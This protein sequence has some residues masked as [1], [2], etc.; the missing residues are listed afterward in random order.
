MTEYEGPADIA[1]REKTALVKKATLVSSSI[2][3]DQP[4][5]ALVPLAPTLPAAGVLIIADET[6]KRLEAQ[7]RNEQ[8]HHRERARFR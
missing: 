1:Q 4:S 7:F 5:R 2:H 6:R 3:D 8:N